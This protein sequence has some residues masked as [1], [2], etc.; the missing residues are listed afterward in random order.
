M[1]KKIKLNDKANDWNG[2]GK[3]EIVFGNGGDDNLSGGGGND[4]LYGG[5][6]NDLLRGGG[7]DDVLTGGVGD[8]TMLGGAGDDT[9]GAQS[10]NDT[11][12]GGDGDDLVKIAGNFADA[13]ITEED[14]YYVIT[15]GTVVTKVKNVELFQFTD[16]TKTAEQIEDALD[17]SEGDDFLLTTAVDNIV[18]TDNNDQVLGGVIDN[19]TIANTTL[20]AAD[21][22]AGGAGDADSLTVTAQGA[23]AADFN[24]L[25]A[26]SITGI[27]TLIVRNVDSGANDG[28]IDGNGI[29]GLT[30]LVNNLSTNDVVASNVADPT[31]I[32][33][34]GNGSVVNGATTATYVAGATSGEL[35]LNGGVNGGAVGVHGAGLTSLT[36]DSTGGVNTTAGISTTG[37]PASVTINAATALNTGGL[38]VGTLATTQTLTIT[39]AAENQAATATTAATGAVVLGFFDADFDVIDAS[40]LTKGGISAQFSAANQV[41]TGGAGDDI[42][43]IAGVLT[44][45]SANAGGGSAD[46]L[47]V[48]ATAS[49]ATAALGAKFTNFEQLQITDAVVANLSN[50][51]G[52]TSVLLNDGAGATE[53][54][55]LTAT[56]AGD[57]T[58]LAGDGSAL[59]GVSG[60]STVGQID[61]VK[62]TFSD[63]DTTGGEDINTSASSFTLTGV[64]NLSVVATDAVEIV[65]SNAWSGDLTSVTLSGA[66]NIS[67]T[68]GDMDQVNF[69]LNASASTGTNILNASGYAT[70]GVAITGGTGVDTITGSAQAD[71]I[72]GG[73]GADSITAGA[74][75]DSITGGDGKDS[76]IFATADIDTTLGAVTDTISDFVSGTDTLTFG[77]GVGSA[78][79]YVEA[80]SAA[81][82]LATLLAAADTALNGTVTYY[83]GQV[84]SDSYVVTDADGTGY[85][86]VVKLTGV[87]LTGIALGD[88]IA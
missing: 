25:G 47:I 42:I 3:P 58:V 5:E 49:L 21:V 81:A 27:E 32:T 51:A 59:I 73:A 26:A 19:T 82:D 77:F 15:I 62:M 11:V 76:F 40:G 41:V 48:G 80:A 84:G 45:G 64:E 78:T 34:N 60:A 7:G 69:A 61:T 44:T 87:A 50:I 14:G 33:I 10:G 18:G 74:G 20:T 65:Q 13:V 6:G 43:S 66:G 9:I 30:S 29:V 24:L 37:T 4:K 86:D 79:S 71:V 16:G 36:I 28:L 46:R 35:V 63:G 68:T 54:Q 2:T 57:I 38:A 39:G 12:D 67:F 55:N 56:Q 72:S 17:G 88:I 85:T 83:V 75:I 22:I 8:D 53:F 70:N 1:A 31:K 23:A 52:I